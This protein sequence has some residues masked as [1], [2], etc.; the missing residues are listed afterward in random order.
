MT[1]LQDHVPMPGRCPV[2]APAGHRV[3]TEEVLAPSTYV[4]YSALGIPGTPGTMLL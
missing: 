4:L 2:W 3:L 1:T